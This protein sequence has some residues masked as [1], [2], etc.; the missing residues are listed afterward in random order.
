MFQL[1]DQTV[2]EMLALET[3][4]PMCHFNLW[5]QV[6]E[7]V[8]VSDAC[9]T[10]GGTC[11]SS[12]LSHLGTKE[13]TLLMD[14]EQKPGQP[15]LDDEVPK[16]EKIVVI[17][18]FAGVGGLPRALERAGVPFCHLIVVE[19]EEDLR[20]LHRRVWPGGEEKIDISKVTVD[21]LVGC[22]QKIP[23]LTGVIAGGG[24]PCQGISTLSSERRHLE[25]ERSALFFKLADLLKGLKKELE[26]RRI[27][28][29]GF[30]EN[31]VGDEEDV[32]TMTRELGYLAYLIDSGHFSWARRPRMFWSS[33]RLSCGESIEAIGHEHVIE[34]ICKGPVE[35]MEAFLTKP[36][37]WPGG[38][39]D[40]NRRFPTFTRAI[41]RKKPPPNPVGLE[42]A[43]Q[44]AVDRWT[45]DRFKYPPYTYA[46]EYM[47]EVEGEPE[48][49][50]PLNS[51][52]REILMG[53]PPGHL[54]KMHRKEPEDEVEKESQEVAA[55]AAIGNS[56][57]TGAM[58]ILADLAMWS[59]GKK[60]VPKGIKKMQDEFIVSLGNAQQ[61]GQESESESAPGGSEDENSEADFDRSSS[62]ASDVTAHHVAR[63]E[64][65]KSQPW[66]GQTL[67]GEEV[68]SRDKR[69]SVAL[70]SQFVRR[71][72]YRGSDVRLDVGL[73]Y[74]PEAYPRTS[75]DPRR[76][77]WVEAHAYP[78]LTSEHI[79]VLELRALVM[80]FEWRSRK[81]S[82]G[83]KRMLHVTEPEV[84]LAVVCKGRSSSMVLNRILRRFAALQ[85]AGGVFPLFAWVESHL[86]PADAPS[87]KF[88]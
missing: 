75:I 69:L 21:E 59:M 16:T 40:P 31:V 58:A 62:E 38:L 49:C 66:R 39:E 36:V 33:E 54:Q 29:W 28:F 27:W 80:A 24:S 12:R 64:R 3:G 13:A 87:R 73:L 25:D 85:L 51:K 1:L 82:W 78:F 6:D 18:F 81:A 70:V 37:V 88:Q 26:E 41:P 61:G 46:R 22:V 56:F 11:Y 34:L 67:L 14:G 32:V 43:Q 55:C 77:Q 15:E 50:R 8:T 45:K 79:N 5:A 30:V 53:F 52:E 68:S 76:W 57:H 83:D 23:A 7:L 86:N 2:D 47:V 60:I 4:L 42:K 48:T 35:P 20:R 65:R 19:R 9:E 10:G 63:V 84:A 71:Q 17:D 72:E 44:D 74:R